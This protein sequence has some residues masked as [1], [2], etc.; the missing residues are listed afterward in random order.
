MNSSVK[1]ILVVKM[2]AIGDVI[3]ALPVS[4]AIKET[5]P[6]AK[7]SWIV[8]PP[9]YDLLTN[10]PC[11]DEIILF[12][13]T[14]FKSVWGLM[15]HLP[16]FSRRLKQ[17]R[18]DVALDL[19]GLAKSAAIAYLSG[20]PRKLGFCNMREFSHWVSRPVCGEH[21][22]GPVV[23]RYLDVAR[24]LGCKVSKVV[25]PVVVTAGEQQQ[26]REL[27]GQAGLDLRQAYILLVPGANWPNKRW[28]A[29]HFARLVNLLWQN[30]QIPVLV[31]GAGDQPLACQISD[32][33]IR[34]PINL[35]GQ[36]SLKQLACLMEYAT[37]LVG[38]DTGP[39]H[40]AAGLKT[41]VVALM[42]PTDANRNGPY[43][44]GHQVVTV[45][46]DCAGCWQRQCP[47]GWD[48][49][50]GITPEQVFQALQT[51]IK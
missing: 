36:T 25:F 20:A 39:M 29:E 51:I 23:E 30:G 46:H 1:N 3:H 43:G 16:A 22:E 44:A 47:K 7:V 33:C 14:Q 21:Q 41:P 49:L 31:G 2:S 37:V 12:E 32:K 28:P 48:C 8:E 38:G 24:A 6:A 34:P 18:F 11:I 19:Q 35:V 27:A 4:Y 5:Y 42:G 45:A 13:K 26:T 10:N 15:T 50:A 40:L 9:A 17:G